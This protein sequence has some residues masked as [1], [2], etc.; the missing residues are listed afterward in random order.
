MLPA[1]MQTGWLAEARKTIRLLAVQPA[2]IVRQGTTEPLPV[3]VALKTVGPTDQDIVN[4]W[5]LGARII[6]L[7][8]DGVPAGVA[9]VRFDRVQIGASIHTVDYV[10]EMRLG[11]ALVAW[12]LYVRGLM[13]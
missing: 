6:T 10:H 11:D 1:D 13:P 7:P 9:P 3:E 4:T 5:G 8:A 12:K 2:F